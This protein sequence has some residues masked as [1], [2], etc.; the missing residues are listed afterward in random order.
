MKASLATTAVSLIFAPFS[1]DRIDITET[2][3]DNGLNYN[4]SINLLL[5][6]AREIF[7]ARKIEALVSVST[8][9][10]KS[11]QIDN[12]LLSLVKKMIEMT[13]DATREAV[14]FSNFLSVTDKNLYN[15][16]FRF[17]ASGKIFNISLQK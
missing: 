2:F 6:E 14:N 5:F 8:D 16:Y 12:K 9:V 1:K 13:T 10:K 4:N 3:V 15:S 7:S 11:M 17:D